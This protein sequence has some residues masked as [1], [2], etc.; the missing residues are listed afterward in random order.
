MEPVVQADY[1]KSRV[2]PTSDHRPHARRSTGSLG[3]CCGTRPRATRSSCTPCRG[4]TNCPRTSTR[5]GTTAYW[6]EAF[7]GVVMRMALLA[8][9]SA[10]R[11]RSA[12]MQTHLRGRDLIDL[13]EW[14]K[15]EIDTVLDVAFTLKRERALGQPHPLPARQGARDAV[16]L[17]EHPHPG[18]VRGGD[19]PARRARPVHREP[20]DPDRARRHGQGDRRDPRPLQRR[21]RDP[22]RRL[23]RRQPVHARGGRGQPG[24]GA[25]H[26]V[27]RL[28]PA[29]GAGRPD[30]DHRAVRRP[31][32]PHGRP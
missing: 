5:P 21:H 30:D 26:A 15:D 2:D 11:S 12:G 18:L 8:W 10:R 19:G 13:Q 14:T 22:V 1:T 31:A 28:P 20:D 29:P 24:A 25:Q 32:R 16:L 3:N 7:N 4:W 17:L 6:V 27:R 9:F 23:G